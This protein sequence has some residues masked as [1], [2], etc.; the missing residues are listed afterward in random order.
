MGRIMGLDIGDKRIGIAV[1][2]PSLILAS[3]LKTLERK[4]DASTVVEIEALL[5]QYDIGRLVIGLPYLLDGTVGEQARKVMEF[6]ARITEQIGVETVMQDERLTS[7][8]A[9]R[10]L[11]E[12]GKKRAGLKKAIDAAAATV[13]LQSYLDD[14]ALGGCIS[15]EEPPSL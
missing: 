1:S 8:T 9:D 12:A 2:D 6:V 14:I 4:D 13:I 7:V 10:M 15:Q 5:R 11:R 3:P